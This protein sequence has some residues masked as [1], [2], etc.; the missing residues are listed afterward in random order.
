MTTTATD[1]RRE[2]PEGAQFAR[3][4]GR[5]LS[6]VV[7]QAVSAP[8]AAEVRV[9]SSDLKSV[10]YDIGSI[11]TCALL[12]A[13]GEVLVDDTSRSWSVFVKVLQSARAWPLIH[14][15]PEDARDFFLSDFPWRIEIDAQ[16]S[17]LAD[18]L[19]DGLR[20]PVLFDVD[21][22]DELHA[23]MWMED[24]PLAS[25][26][27]TSHTFQRAAALLGE[28][29]GRRPIGSDAV[30]GDLTYAGQPGFALRE[31]ANGRVHHWAGGAL[32]NDAIWEHP[33]LRAA[34]RDEDELGGGGLR[35][36]LL[37]AFDDI[38]TLFD[39]VDSLPH[40]YVHGDASPQNLLVSADHPDRFVAIDWG[41][42]CPLA[43]GFDLGQLLIGL[44]HAGDL[45]TDEL[46]A[47]YEV[48][49]RA[50]CEGL[51]RTD[52]VAT[53]GEVLAGFVGSMM[54]RSGF[55]AMPYEV[56]ER[57]D[58]PD[59]PELRANLRSRIALTR[60]ILDL[61]GRVLG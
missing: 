12:R 29:A 38:P 39:L 20:L 61:T 56:F 51:S 47:T 45:G 44:A 13:K 4:C 2:V 57:P 7:R 23:A 10:P 60:F 8:A 27:W 37:R 14:L 48:I 42:N 52:F 36:D 17:T 3:L 59:S 1:A 43:I 30:F 46:Q 55:T 58:L 28:L 40:T 5:R 18:A 34:L 50:Y 25:H 16:R 6:S 11:S 54:L 26:P 41:F 33:S 15:I 49:V 21:E 22:V 32:G 24:V 35:A 19:P 9:V 53:E 31:Y